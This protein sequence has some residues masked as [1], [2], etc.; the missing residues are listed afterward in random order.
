MKDMKRR[1]ISSEDLL[2]KAA[3]MISKDL[4]KDLQEYEDRA[5]T[6]PDGEAPLDENFLKFAREYD[7]EHRKKNGLR[8]ILK[9]AAVFLISLTVLGGITME[10]SEAFRAKI[11]DMVFHKESGVVSMNPSTQSKD[12]MI[13]D[14]AGYWYPEYLP[15]GC[16]LVDSEDHSFMISFSFMPEDEEYQIDLCEYEPDGL[17]MQHNMDINTMEEVYVGE[18]KAYLF[19]NEK[20]KTFSLVWQAENRVL[21]LSAFNYTDREELFKIAESVKYVE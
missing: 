21:K 6:L 14:M 11:F 1:E 18:Y 15:D 16:E 20:D 19:T 5:E 3:A 2:K 8:R 4:E 10:A 9:T 12:E 7:G 17:S 13:A